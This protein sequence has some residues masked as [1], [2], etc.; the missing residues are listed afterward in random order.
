MSELKQERDGA[1][2][3]LGSVRRYGR[4]VYC[5]DVGEKKCDQRLLLF[6]RSLVEFVGRLEFRVFVCREA[7]LRF[8]RRSAFRIVG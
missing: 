3:L 5:D 7:G 4:D 2:L 6:E 1:F 8:G